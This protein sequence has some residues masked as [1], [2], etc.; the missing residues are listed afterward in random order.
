MNKKLKSQFSYMYNGDVNICN[1]GLRT[2]RNNAQKV[3]GIGPSIEEV[4]DK[5]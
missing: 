2:K 4:L 1:T 3:L 5:S